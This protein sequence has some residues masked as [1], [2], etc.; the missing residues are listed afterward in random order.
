MTGAQEV[1]LGVPGV[2][3]FSLGTGAGAGWV[4]A[5]GTHSIVYTNYTHALVTTTIQRTAAMHAFV[6][7]G[8]G[9]HQWLHHFDGKVGRVLHM[10]AAQCAGGLGGDNGR[11]HL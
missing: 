10:A 1:H 6:M 8:K 3:V 9:L 2:R 4:I 5:L 7:G 11:L